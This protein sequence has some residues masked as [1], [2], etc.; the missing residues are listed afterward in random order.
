MSKHRKR[1]RAMRNIHLPADP[2]LHNRPTRE[3]KQLNPEVINKRLGQGW[4]VVFKVLRVEGK[5]WHLVTVG[6]PHCNGAITAL[7]NGPATL[8]KF[9]KEEISRLTV[10]EHV[11]TEHRSKVQSFRKELLDSSLPAELQAFIKALKG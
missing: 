2:E 9:A 1:S 11:R 5:R 4:F 3:D 10:L 7:A 8:P 6:C